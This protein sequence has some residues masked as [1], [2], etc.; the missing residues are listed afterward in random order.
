MFSADSEKSQPKILIG[1]EISSEEIWLVGNVVLKYKQNH[2]GR[3][4]ETNN[5]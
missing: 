1:L 4:L 2:W 5:Q 3:R